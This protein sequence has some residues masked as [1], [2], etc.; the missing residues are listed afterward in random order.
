MK[1]YLIGALICLL[2]ALAFGIEPVQRLVNEVTS[3]GTLRGVETCIEYSKSDLLSQDAVRASCVQSFQ[4]RLYGPDFATGL[5]GPRMEQEKLGW[6]GTLE[7]KTP[8][9]VTTWIRIA[10]TIF[11]AD[12]AKQEVFAETPIWIDPLDEAEFWVELPDLER[13]Q[14]D[15]IAFCDIDD[16][17]PKACFGWGVTEVMGLAI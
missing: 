7:N 11:D 15:N 8:D 10:V 3:Q 14:L 9:H 17:T 4:K 12:G 2:A 1:N 6:G 13:E 16:E 5:A